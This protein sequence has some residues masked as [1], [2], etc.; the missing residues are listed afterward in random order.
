MS[1]NGGLHSNCQVFH[2]WKPQ[3]QRLLGMGARAE[4]FAEEE[5]E[6][7]GMTVTRKCAVK[8]KKVIEW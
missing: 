1:L 8:D 3:T 2:W 5:K 6:E 7:R 4:C